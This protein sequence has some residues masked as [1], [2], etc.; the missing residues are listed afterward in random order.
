MATQS[1]FEM[2]ANPDSLQIFANASLQEFDANDEIG[3]DIGDNTGVGGV[4]DIDAFVVDGVVETGSKS[5]Y[6]K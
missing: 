3:D 5:I 2:N 1:S 4:G 6:F